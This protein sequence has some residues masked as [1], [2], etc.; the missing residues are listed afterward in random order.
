M[1]EDEP[2]KKI[3][4]EKSSFD[5]DD[6]EP[7]EQPSTATEMVPPRQKFESSHQNENDEHEN[8]L[9]LQTDTFSQEKQLK[10]LEDRVVVIDGP[11]LVTENVLKSYKLYK[12]KSRK[13]ME[14][15]YD[16]CV[17]R[18]YSDFEYLQKQLIENYGGCIIPILPEKNFWANVNMEGEE[19]IKNRVL[20]LEKYIK[21]LLA[22]DRLRSTEELSHFLFSDEAKFS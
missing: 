2:N 3:H 6:D 1:Q 4:L 21:S 20:A 14:D 7:I 5:L 11:E 10:F 22:H 12:I 8:L 13:K 19:Y 17:A 18:R 15:T 9:D 16:T